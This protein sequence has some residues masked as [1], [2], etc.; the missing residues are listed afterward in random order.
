MEPD[1][2]YVYLASLGLSPSAWHSRYERMRRQM[3]V[4]RS[5]LASLGQA[6]RRLVVLSLQGV[7]SAEIAE[8]LGYASA[9]VVRQKRRR[10][11]ARLRRD[12]SEQRSPSLFED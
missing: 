5:M 12:F 7:P 4:S 1:R 3:E 11:Y 10:I 8:E 9:D 6:D 2:A